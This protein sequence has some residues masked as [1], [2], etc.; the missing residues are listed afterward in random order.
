MLDVSALRI[1]SLDACH[2]LGALCGAAH[3]H[4]PGFDLVEE[5]LLGPEDGPRT[6]D[7]DPTDER[8]SGEPKVLH[9]VQRDQGA[10]ATKA[11]LAVNGDCAL[12]LLSFLHPLFSDVVGGRRSVHELQ[13]QVLNTLLDKLLPVICRLV[14]SDD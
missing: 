6:S 11:G 2:Q 9:R 4:V 10:R 12:F 7:P 14:K 5:V 1:G 8:G 3:R 13:I